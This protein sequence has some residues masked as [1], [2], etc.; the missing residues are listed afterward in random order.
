MD[1]KIVQ[2]EVYADADDVVRD[3]R[4]GGKMPT[5]YLEMFQI[6]HKI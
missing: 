1:E 5:E 6:D 3:P 4:Y 2:Q